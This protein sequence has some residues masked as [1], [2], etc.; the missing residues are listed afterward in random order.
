MTKLA[1]QKILILSFLTSAL[2]LF[3][4]SHCIS[5]LSV[6]PVPVQWA[7]MCL[8]LSKYNYQLWLKHTLHATF[9]S[10]KCQTNCSQ[11]L[12][13]YKK[14]EN[15]TQILKIKFKVY[16]KLNTSYLHTSTCLSGNYS[17]GENG[18]SGSLCSVL[19]LVK[20]KE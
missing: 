7:R 6:H 4:L 10:H 11:T 9:I 8:S 1:S 14:Y 19:C 3:P 20:V 5:Y 12:C 2:L 15:K 13:M 16:T 17:P 18:I